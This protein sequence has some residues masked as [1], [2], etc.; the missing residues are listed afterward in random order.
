MTLS[1]R[2]G[3]LGSRALW[4]AGGGQLL[5]LLVFVAL[6]TVVARFLPATLSGGLLV[7]LGI[8]VA[9][10]PAAIWLAFFYQQDRLEP[11][12]KSYLL[13]VF[14]LGALVASG[15]GIPLVRDV[16]RVNDWLYRDPLTHLLGS[17]FAVGFVQEFL[18]FAAVRFSIY[19]SGEFDERVDGII[20][21]TAAA[22]G[23]A[24][25]LNINYIVSRGGVDLGVGVIRVTV[26]ALA[27]ASISGVLGYF[28]GQAKFERTPL[29]YLP[30]GYVLAAVLNGVFF[31]AQDIVT[32]QG[33]TVNPF[34]GLVLAIVV[35]AALLAL[36]YWL[37]QRANSETLALQGRS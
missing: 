8:V 34:N 20:Y 9:L 30:A 32:V 28:L 12:P 6:G 15:L 25:V 23:F 22:L 3:V 19:N 27:Q 2:S 10:I 13:A 18:K 37:I 24:T 35:A 4:A 29:Y 17:I 26:M 33:L 5:A 11:E 7:V 36:V 16:L 21:A 1:T 31:W 14:V